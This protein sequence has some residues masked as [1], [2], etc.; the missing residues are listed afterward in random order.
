MDPAG[1]GGRR[2]HQRETGDQG[3]NRGGTLPVMVKHVSDASFVLFLDSVCHEL[4]GDAVPVVTIVV[5]CTSLR[6]VSN[7]LVGCLASVERMLE[8][9]IIAALGQEVSPQ[10]FAAFARFQMHKLLL[11]DFRP[12]PLS[13]SI[14][15]TLAH[16]ADGTVA[17][18]M[19]DEPVQVLTQSFKDDQRLSFPIGAATTVVLGG[20]RYLHGWLIPHFP[21]MHPVRLHLRARATRFGSFVLV[22]GVVAG[23]SFFESLVVLNGGSEVRCEGGGQFQERQEGGST[24]AC[25]CDVVGVLS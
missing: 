13:Y 2:S 4:Q 16:D 21:G 7:R 24:M 10:D 18:E 19:D 20:A 25:Q 9:K 1:R 12:L 23:W 3:R 17:L 14:R 15:R 6:E 8:R 5:A 22:L 11:P